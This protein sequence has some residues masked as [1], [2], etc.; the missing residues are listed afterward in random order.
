MQKVTISRAKIKGKK[1]M[2]SV[3]G[4]ETFGVDLKDAAKKFGKRFAASSS[5]KDL[6]GG[7]GKEVIIQGDV[8]E[9]VAAWIEVNFGVPAGKINVKAGK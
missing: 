6:A 3:V 7:G 8:G 4:L 1:S 2:T 5:V 9:D